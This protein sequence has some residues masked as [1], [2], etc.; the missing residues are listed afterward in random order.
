MNK[1]PV[2]NIEEIKE[3]FGL[4]IKSH[5]IGSFHLKAAQVERV[6]DMVMEIY[7]D[8]VIKHGDAPVWMITWPAAFGLAEYLLLNRDCAGMKVLE[9]GCGTAAPGVAL[10]RAGAS[11]VCTDFD[12]MTLEMA[13]YNAELNGCTSLELEYLD[14][15]QPELEENFDL[16]IGS[17]IVYFEKSFNP[18]MEVMRKYGAG[19]GEIIF[20]DQGRPQMDRFL[21]LC[22]EE[23]FSYSEKRQM[24]YLPEITKEIRIFTFS[25]V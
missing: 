9:L 2:L 17:D 8:A 7:P 19:G 13:R 18:L 6:D 15:Y 23:G 4:V 16:V 24:V 1:Q 21:E 25:I 5:R 3:R 20:S 10:E 14:W 12:Y 22:S 11:V